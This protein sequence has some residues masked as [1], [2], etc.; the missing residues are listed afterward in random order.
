MSMT[1]TDEKPLLQNKAKMAYMA[2]Q[3]HGLRVRRLSYDILNPELSF[4]LDT[5]ILLSDKNILSKPNTFQMYMEDIGN[6]K[7]RKTILLFIDHFDSD[8]ESKLNDALG[9]LVTGNAWFSVMYSNY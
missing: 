5:L 7:I 3:K 2:F 9:H 8:Q 1:T 6:H 4:D